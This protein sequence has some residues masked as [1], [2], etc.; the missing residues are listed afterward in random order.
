MF[1]ES[2]V[3]TVNDVTS[4]F[5]LPRVRL[6]YHIRRRSW[7]LKNKPLLQ[8]QLVIANLIVEFSLLS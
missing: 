5:A 6:S 4:L 1:R 3:Y 8:P 7:V 2:E